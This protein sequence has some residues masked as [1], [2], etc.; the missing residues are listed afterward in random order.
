[1]NA[2]EE[3]II[4]QDTEIR[5]EARSLETTPMRACMVAYTLYESDNR[6]RRYAETLVRR[7][8][9]VDV[10]ALREVGQSK[11]VA[12]LNG[13]RLFR[14]QSRVRNEKSKFAYLSKLLLFFLR[15]MFFLT[16]EQV[17]RRYDLIH[18]HSVPDFEVF[19][20]LY[21]K[22]TGSKVILDIHDIVPEFYA[23]KFNTSPMSLTFK[24]LVKVERVS[25]A[26][27]DHVIVANH[28]WE[29]RL[30]RRSVRPSKLTTILNF[31]DTQIFRQHGRNRCDDKFIMLYPGTLSYHQ[32]LDIAIRA[33]SLVK[34]DVPNAEFHIYGGGDQQSVLKS[35]IAELGLQGRVFL[36]GVLSTEDITSVIE[37]ADLGVVPKRKSGFGNEAFSTK[38]LEFMSMGVPV[39]VPDTTI[40]K[41][42]FNES[43]VKFFQGDDQRSLADAMLQLS[44]DSK[45]RIKLVQNANEFVKEYTWGANQGAYLDIVDALV[46]SKNGHNV[47]CDLNR[48]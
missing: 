5:T 23:S 40:D 4:D 12:I 24:L 10:V 18:V 33:F 39:I 2:L 46:N 36:K 19:A 34:D 25:A 6:V 8:Y 17:K 29:E 41:Y 32:G 15:S 38:I 20:A 47:S 16:R 21:P 48:K 7:G 3:Q 35:L 45:L 31:P 9:Q 37:N 26:F 14:V 42:Y 22:I 30:Q 1:M 11:D 44:K 28:L 43:V 13:V 27:S